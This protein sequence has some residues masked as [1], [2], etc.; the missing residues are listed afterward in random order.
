M[1]RSAVA[2]IALVGT[3]SCLAPAPR[4]AALAGQEAKSSAD[5]SG[6]VVV[7]SFKQGLQYRLDLVKEPALRRLGGKEFLVGEC[8][9]GD[10]DENTAW[11]GV[12]LWVPVEGVEHLLTF[13]EYVPARRALDDARSKKAAKGN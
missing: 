3:V 11:T 7:V 4:S 10:G 9:V 1:T 5:F 8:D 2:L 13:K 6:K 12:E